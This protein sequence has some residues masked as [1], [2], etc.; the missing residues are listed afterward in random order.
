VPTYREA[1]NLRPLAERVFAATRAAGIEAELIIVDDNSQDGSK[2][3]IQDLAWDYDIRI[4]VR[5]NERGLSSAVVAGFG[6]AKHDTLLVMD[7]DLSHPPESVPALVEPIFNGAADFVVGSRYV[8]G[9]RVQEEWPLLRRLNSWGATLL[10]RPLTPVRDP[11]A[12]FFCLRKETWQRARKLNPI[13]Y[14][15]ALELMVKCRCRRFVEVPIVFADR[16]RG[17]SKL[18]ARQQWLYLRQLAGLYWFRYPAAITLGAVL[19]TSLVL[20]WILR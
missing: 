18:T 17:E 2:E 4:H 13:G 3:I 7:A 16:V 19:A 11:M 14:K 20:W 15:I 10:A 1:E 5:Q 8:G 9:G 6:L 12:G